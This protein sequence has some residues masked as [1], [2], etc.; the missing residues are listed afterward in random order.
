MTGLVLLAAGASVR[1]GEPKQNLNFRGKTLLQH[2]VQ[3]ATA[4]VC[5]PVIVVLGANAEA[6]TSEI[7]QESISVIRNQEWETG[8]ASSIRC[9]LNE[10][11][12]QAPQ[13][14]NI[15][16]MLCDQPFVEPQIL[17]KLVQTNTETG[18]EVIACSYQ[19]TLGTPALFHKTM[20]PE[21]LALTGD[22]GAKK[23][24]FRH[25]ETVAMVLFPLGAIDIDT[26]AD[27]TALQDTN[28]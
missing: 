17:N 3:A 1:L 28:I 12:R 6:F 18:K 21:L 15:I 2:A 9:G 5:K 24:I 19:D 23:L 8:M 7:Q 22:E 16:F 20:F 4:S 13:T 26:P 10:L 14:T 25:Q 11:L 27:Y